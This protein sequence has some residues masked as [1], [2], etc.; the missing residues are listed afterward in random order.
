MRA[1]SL[2]EAGEEK[3]G[4]RIPKGARARR[5]R[6]KIGTLLN[7]S[8]W[9]KHTEART[10]MKGGGGTGSTGNGKR[11]VQTPVPGAPCHPIQF[12]IV[13]F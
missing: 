12:P 3:A 10:T 11:E 4:D 5:N 1:G 8:Q 9:E 13:K 6:E 2:R 7:I